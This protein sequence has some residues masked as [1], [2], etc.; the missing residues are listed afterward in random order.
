M[1][2][3]TVVASDRR[4]IILSFGRSGSIFTAIIENTLNDN[5]VVYGI[6]IDE[7][8]VVKRVRID[9]LQDHLASQR[10]LFFIL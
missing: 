4:G 10:L 1:I 9:S 8:N 5:G 7:D 3:E 2:P 6:I